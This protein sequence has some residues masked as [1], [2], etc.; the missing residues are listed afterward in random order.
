M[1]A[2]KVSVLTTN[3]ITKIMAYDHRMRPIPHKNS[4]GVSINGYEEVTDVGN[5][6]T[7]D[8]YVPRKD[9]KRKDFETHSE[10][11][12]RTALVK[13][14]PTVRL[15]EPKPQLFDWEKEI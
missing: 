7:F 6:K 8:R 2:L 15:V 4:N 13:A 3:V 10:W 12:R 11:K 5:D 1:N 9:T 14:K